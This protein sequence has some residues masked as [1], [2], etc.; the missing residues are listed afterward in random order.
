V[1]LWWGHFL[2]PALPNRSLGS[3]FKNLSWF[4]W[5]VWPLALWTLWH[6]H[7]RL[8]RAT[9]L[10][11]VLAALPVT[12]LLGLWPS[13]A[14]GSG[15]LPALIPLSLLAAHGVA[16]LKRGAAQGF[17]WF[18]VVCFLFFALAFWVYF[19]AI[20]WGWPYRL[21][22]QLSRLV[23]AY[24]HQQA[25]SAMRLAAVVTL[26][27]LIAIP[28][29]P[30]AK[31]RPVLVWATGMALSWLLLVALFWPWAEAGWGYRPQLRAMA[32]HLPAGACLRADVDAA[33]TTM[34]RLHLKDRYRSHGDCHWWL[35]TGEREDFAAR[36]WPV[37]TVWTGVRPRDRRS[38]YALIRRDEP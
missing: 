1:T 33:M 24:T 15:L 30:R 12:L 4:A 5:P 23:P 31:I 10:H 20:E 8:A 34:L 22:V 7:R 26:C 9:A 6:E 28:L 13:H 25:D 35:V 37:E 19:A 16:E 38:Y 3:L 29:F 2:A 11:P 27:W 18:G 32:A 14:S 36:T 17:Y 21:A